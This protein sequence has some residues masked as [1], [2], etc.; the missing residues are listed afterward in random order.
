MKIRLWTSILIKNFLLSVILFSCTNT[1]AAQYKYAFGFGAS[2]IGVGEE[3]P[4]FNAF[5]AP[6]V[7]AAYAFLS[8]PNARASIEGFMSYRSKED[9][10]VTRNGFNF[11]LPIAFEYR[12]PKL[13]IYAGIGP[14][15]HRE[16]LVY[17]DYKIKDAGYYW[18]INTGL[19][20][21]RK[22]TPESLQGAVN[23]RIHYLKSFK[24][25]RLDGLVLSLYLSAPR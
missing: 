23:F 11:S 7:Y 1:A 17:D 20:F 6:T 5:V 3:K 24:D 13:S 22:S 21:G 10:S 14:S 9:E 19:G 4:D 25:Q 18:D 12:L 15:Y 8:A 16:A 2:A